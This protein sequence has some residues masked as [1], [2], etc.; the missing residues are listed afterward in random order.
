MI[1]SGEAKTLR[2]HE[3][4][5]E[6]PEG[7]EVRT[8]CFHVGGT[9]E[10]RVSSFKIGFNVGLRLEGSGQRASVIKG[11]EQQSCRSFSSRV[12]KGSQSSGNRHEGGSSTE[13]RQNS[14]LVPSVVFRD[15]RSK[16][17]CRPRR[18]DRRTR[19]MHKPFGLHPILKYQKKGIYKRKRYHL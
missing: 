2:S 8:S 5:A 14:Q 15:Q 4:E 13:P 16:V 3:A 1:L 19:G 6:R 11:C 18:S 17:G 9:K 12:Q 7:S 10:S